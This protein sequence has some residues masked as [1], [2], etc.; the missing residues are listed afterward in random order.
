LFDPELPSIGFLQKPFVARYLGTSE[1][2][3]FVYYNFQNQSWMGKDTA[4]R[5]LRSSLEQVYAREDAIRKAVS[6]EF[7]KQYVPEELN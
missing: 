6:T 7:L 5:F 3:I 1:Q 4:E 2:S